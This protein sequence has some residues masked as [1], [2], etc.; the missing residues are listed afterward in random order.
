MIR[1]SMVMLC[2][3]L[4]GAAAGRYKAEASV[5]AVDAEIRELAAQKVAQ[6]RAIQVLRTEL[7]Q[8]ESPDRLAELAEAHTEL[9]PLSGAQ[10]LTSDD[11]LVAFGRPETPDSDFANSGDAP[12]REVPAQTPPPGAL[13][14]AQ[15]EPL[16]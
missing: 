7:A 2:M 15:P 14:A 6:Q 9:K 10:L 5:R 16:D 3:V 12:A 8:L 13:A 1:I 4:F 11:F